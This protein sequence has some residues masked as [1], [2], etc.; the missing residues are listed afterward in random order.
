[1]VVDGP[2]AWFLGEGWALSPETA[3]VANADRK[4]PSAGGA[5]G[6][7][8]RH[9]A[10][11]RL[12]IGGRNLAGPGAPKARFTMTLGGRAVDTWEVAPTPGFFLRSVELPPAGP[13][14]PAAGAGGPDFD[15][16]RVTSSAA[17]GSAQAVPTAIEQFGLAPLDR[18]QFAFAEGWHEDEL[19]PRTGLRWRWSGGRA[20]V[21]AWPV[22]RDLR[23]RL[24][25]ESPLKTF[26]EAPIVTMTAGALEV[27]RVTPGDAFTIDAIVPAAALAA[28]G[29]RLVIATSRT[30][31]PAEH[32][33]AGDPRHLD[34]RA[35]GL[36]LF[37]AS[38]SDAS[39]MV[40]QR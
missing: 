26:A 10:A 25:F 32:V 27:A 12:V 30:Y 13:P 24:D 1:M 39:A 15:E 16:V 36:R 17:D 21:Q 5:V 34:R 7:V 38:V 3:G 4:G 8:R 14:G 22:D 9:G 29:G 40:P 35:L 28:S 23:V 19:Q 6:W 37:E 2:P 33:G 11:R 18:V 31:V 20:V